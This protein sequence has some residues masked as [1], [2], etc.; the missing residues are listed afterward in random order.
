MNTGQ[1]KR[2][3]LALGF[4]T[5]ALAGPSIASTEAQVRAPTARTI[6]PCDPEGA[7]Y[8]AARAEL[9]AIDAAID[10][11][12][13]AGDFAAL[14]GRI[15]D[16]TRGLCFELM[17]ASSGQPT[18]ALS[19][20]TYWNAGG[21]SRLLG[22]LEL[23]KPAPIVWVEPSF[24]RA[25]TIETSP[26]SPLRALLCSAADHA[27]AAETRGWEIRAEAAFVRAARLVADGRRLQARERDRLARAHLMHD[28]CAEIAKGAK[29]G[30]RF[31]RFRDCLDDQ[32]DRRVALPIGHVRA[33]VRGWLVI[34]GR[35]GHHQF[36]DET[37]A[38][39]LSTGSAYRVGTCTSLALLPDGAVDHRATDDGRLRVVEM[40]RV[41]VEALRETAWALLLMDE[42]DKNVRVE[43]W[44]QSL[45]TGIPIVETVSPEGHLE[46][47][48]LGSS[49]T[50][51]SGDTTLIWREVDAEEIKSGTLTWP[52]E[53]NDP[54]RDHALT[55]LKVAEAGF[56]A[57]C[58]AAAPPL[59]LIDESPRLSAHRPDNDETSLDLAA[60]LVA[61]SWQ[62]VLARQ[63]ACAH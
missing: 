47:H 38:Y 7:A 6:R 59:S 43:G 52:E 5:L 15:S 18:S 2:R 26:R 49:F 54:E 21:H 62:E 46:L 12:T 50:L 4:V 28:D 29:V 57:G 60:R 16:L 24:R 42:V 36:C 22:Y 14:V 35:R 41:P 23:V 13:P 1:M 30:Q 17:Q 53:R 32:P 58:P 34:S 40:G 56:T 39:D 63:R 61:D 51:S 10:K 31:I 27:C 33:P 48:G 11:L 44:G 9:E 55:L 8:A 45:P 25:L 20:K 3:R 19:L 37:R